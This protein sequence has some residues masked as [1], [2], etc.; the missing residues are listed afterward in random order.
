MQRF[1]EMIRITFTDDGPGISKANLERIFDPF[2]TTKDEGKGTGLGL[3][4]CFGIIQEHGGHL[5]ARSE[6]DNGATFVIEI[7]ILSEPR[8]IAEGI[9]LIHSVAAVT[10]M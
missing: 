1:D 2:F 10:R 4:I 5:Y 6:P 9:G 8:P 7:P 3:S